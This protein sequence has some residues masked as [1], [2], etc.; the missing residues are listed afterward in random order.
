MRR[1]ATWITGHRKT[2]I[3]GWI[4]ALVVIGAIAGNKGSDFSEEF[5]LPS[6]G[7]TEAYE[8]LE[9]EFG[10]Q[11][12]GTATIV[13]KAEGPDGVNSPEVKQKMEGVFKSVEEKPHVTEVASPYGGG[14]G[15]AAI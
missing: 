2:V 10:G 6:S 7:S 11:S 15:A 5:K 1:F 14:E 8:L 9:D 4:L 13:W 3:I 12:G